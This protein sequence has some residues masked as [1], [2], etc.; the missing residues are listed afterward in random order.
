[1]GEQSVSDEVPTD[2]ASKRFRGNMWALLKKTEMLHD[3][4]KPSPPVLKY[5]RQEPDALE[6]FLTMTI[7]KNRTPVLRARTGSTWI[8]GTLLLASM[9]ARIAFQLYSVCNIRRYGET[10]RKQAG[11]YYRRLALRLYLR[12]LSNLATVSAS[13]A[14]F[15]EEIV[16]Y[17]YL[18][19]RMSLENSKKTATEV[20][21]EL[22]EYLNR[23]LEH[24]KDS[25]ERMSIYQAGGSPEDT[26][27][28]RLI[29]KAFDGSVFEFVDVEDVQPGEWDAVFDHSAPFDLSNA[30][31]N[32]FIKLLYALALFDTVFASIDHN[33]KAYAASLGDASRRAR[34]VSEAAR[35][36]LVSSYRTHAIV[37]QLF[38]NASMRDIAAK[39]LKSEV[40]WGH[41]DRND[42]DALADA[43]VSSFMELYYTPVQEQPRDIEAVRNTQLAE[44]FSGATP[45][46]VN[47][48]EKYE[49]WWCARY[50]ISAP[51]DSVAPRSPASRSHADRDNIPKP[52][53]PVVA[54]RRVIQFKSEPFLNLIR[55]PNVDKALRGMHKFRILPD[56]I[57]FRVTSKQIGLMRLYSFVMKIATAWR[58]KDRYT[59]PTDQ[60]SQQAVLDFKYATFLHKDAAAYCALY[61]KRV[62]E[63]IE[64]AYR[65]LVDKEVGSVVDADAE[66]DKLR[67]ALEYIDT[68]IGAEREAYAN[69]DTYTVKVGSRTLSETHVR[70]VLERSYGVTTTET[71][72]LSEYERFAKFVGSERTHDVNV[73]EIR[74]DE[75]DETLDYDRP[76]RTYISYYLTM[77]SWQ[78]AYRLVDFVQNVHNERARD[79]IGAEVVSMFRQHQ[80]IM[81]ANKRIIFGNTSK[82]MKDIFRTLRPPTR[83][84]FNTTN[85]LVTYAT[86]LSRYK[87]S[88]DDEIQ[89]EGERAKQYMAML[90]NKDQVAKSRASK[91]LEPHGMSEEQIVDHMHS[92]IKA[93]NMCVEFLEYLEKKDSDHSD[94]YEYYSSTKHNSIFRDMLKWIDVAT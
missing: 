67:A 62:Y 80:T 64:Q 2:P 79:A 42:A 88:L 17:R 58:F 23:E 72:H 37:L 51:M 48:M 85:M 59:D 8:I 19:K 52:I 36:S 68:R 55:A 1:M 18:A 40:N 73:D 91:R 27:T 35:V 38:G 70:G 90:Q 20:V 71:P 61:G 30:D 94:L 81:Y 22:F 26:V 47:M 60:A 29:G 82:F 78:I 12:H 21:G 66:T 11:R 65:A 45:S 89:S 32:L 10:T 50:S 77:A 46:F 13:L 53:K 24:Q 84:A 86:L 15:T 56:R 39:L 49:D 76:V 44:R 43:Y 4:H 3:V 28:V 57:Q 92:I 34:D 54:K 25:A 7:D 41:H 9:F 5:I 31:P 87:A 74:I 69:I 75:V 83:N 14:M 93:L 63:L 16:V 33:E 6:G